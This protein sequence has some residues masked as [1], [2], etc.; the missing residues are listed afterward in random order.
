LAAAVVPG[1]K[2]QPL[3]KLDA[4][5]ESLFGFGISEFRG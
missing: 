2:R 5:A 3:K 4:D 1:V